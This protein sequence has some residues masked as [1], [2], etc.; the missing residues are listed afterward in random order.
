[1]AVIMGGGAFFAGSFMARQEGAKQQVIE[2]LLAVVKSANVSSELMEFAESQ[3]LSPKGL[4]LI[5]YLFPGLAFLVPLAAGISLLRWNKP[6]PRM[7]SPAVHTFR[8][9]PRE[10]HWAGF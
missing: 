1:M 7:L 4:M 10:D 8:R 6:Y 9:V 3:V 2:E 5:R